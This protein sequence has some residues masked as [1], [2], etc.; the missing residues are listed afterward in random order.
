MLAKR[1]PAY[2]GLETLQRSELIA[3]LVAEIISA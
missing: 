1:P 3:D 2:G